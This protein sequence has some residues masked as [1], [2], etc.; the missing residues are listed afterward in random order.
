MINHI[1]L[2]NGWRKHNVNGKLHKFLVFIGF[3]VSPTFEA[4]KSSSK[5]KE[6]V[7]EHDAKLSESISSIIPE[8]LNDPM[9]VKKILKG[10][11]ND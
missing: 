10:E 5:F 7:I 9:V 6:F 8:T 2:W 3:T 1:K 4:Y 11:S